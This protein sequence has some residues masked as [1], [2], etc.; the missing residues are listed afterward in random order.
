MKSLFGYLR[1][2]QLLIG[3]LVFLVGFTLT[4]YP[5]YSVVNLPYVFDD[6]PVYVGNLSAMLSGNPDLRGLTPGYPLFLLFCGQLSPDA[7]VVTYVQSVTTLVVGI[8]FLF[9]VR[10]S[11]ESLVLPSSVALTIFTSSLLFVHF[12]TTILT[13]C[14]FANSIVLA[15]G[16]VMLVA[17]EMSLK[18]MLCFSLFVALALAIRPAALFLFPLWL[19]ALGL[20]IARHRSAKHLLFA[21]APVA[22][23]FLLISALRTFATQTD[24]YGGLVFSVATNTLSY[25]NQDPSLPAHVNELIKDY[26]APRQIPAEQIIIQSSQ[27]VKNVSALYLK[28]Q[29]HADGFID[30]LI[31]RNGK[32]YNKINND[33]RAIA[34]LALRKH[35]SEMKRFFEIQFRH[36]FESFDYRRTS[37]YPFFESFQTCFRDARV[38]NYSQHV[39]NRTG[40]AGS[41]VM[42]T[43]R[44]SISDLQLKYDAITD[45]C[46]SGWAAQYFTWHHK[47][48]RNKYWVYGFFLQAVLSILI[49]AFRTKNRGVAFFVLALCA[50]NLTYMVVV[51]V[52]ISMIRYNF[53]LHFVFYLVSML[54][55]PMVLSAVRRDRAPALERS[56]SKRSSRVRTG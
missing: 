23:Y 46:R 35:S 21:V 27:D 1:D 17:A 52:N 5:Y 56:L 51:S 13:E 42:R 33:Y 7:Q 32:D 26:V 6:T 48:F 50:A 24:R 10:R 19:V 22:L 30:S 55:I 28:Y 53:P 15:I 4:R 9:M 38:V 36:Y 2:N 49:I 43:P 3:S 11:F 37:A 16:G 41:R 29:R 47:V 12:E 20:L 18:R 40:Y 25:L 39:F 31:A 34:S 14:L 8:A 44:Y 45:Y 54:I